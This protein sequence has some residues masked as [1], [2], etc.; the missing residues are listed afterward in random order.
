LSVEPSTEPLA[1]RVDPE[2]MVQVLVNLLLNG[3]EAMTE[4]GSLTVWVTRHAP[5]VWIGV[6]DTGPGVA[7]EMQKELFRPFVT[8]KHQGT[9]LGLPISREIVN[10]HGGSLTLKSAPGEG[11]TFVVTLPMA[12]GG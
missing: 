4:R 8:T 9:G 6:S 1:V 11:A 3:I 2:L 5:D 7:A 10:R 12:E